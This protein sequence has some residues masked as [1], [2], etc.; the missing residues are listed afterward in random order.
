MKAV[1]L[2]LA[3]LHSSIHADPTLSFKGFPLPESTDE[4]EQSPTILTPK[5]IPTDTLAISPQALALAGYVQAT[6]ST[7]WSL[8]TQS[9]RMLLSSI[10]MARN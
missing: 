6:P 10:R 8:P 3:I 2:A 7:A 5:D 1:L 9:A 4:N